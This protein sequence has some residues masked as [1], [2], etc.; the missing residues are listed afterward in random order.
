MMLFL[1]LGIEL[2]F[3]YADILIPWNDQTMVK[4]KLQNSKYFQDTIF[5]ARLALWAEPQPGQTSRTSSIRLRWES[6][7]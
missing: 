4:M 5:T 6:V 7:P 3:F 1:H 2:Y